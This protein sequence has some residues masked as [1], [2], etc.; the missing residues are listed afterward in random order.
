MSNTLNVVC[1]FSIRLNLKS[2]CLTTRWWKKS[3][4]VNKQ[5]HKWVHIVTHNG[6]LPLKRKKMFK[7]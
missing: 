3:K 2:A 4:N 6:R 7:M 1:C 5:G